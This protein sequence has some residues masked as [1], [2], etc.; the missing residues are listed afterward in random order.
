MSSRYYDPEIGRFTNADKVDLLGANGDLVS[1]NLF[2]YCGNNPV[3]RTDS[4]GEAYHILIGAAVGLVAGLVGQV[5]TDVTTRLLTGEKHIS[6]WQTYVG[7][8]VGGAVGG[9][10]LAATGNV[11]ASNFATGFFTTGTS[12]VL[13]KVF[14]E[15]DRSWGEIALNS[16]RDGAVSLALGAFLPGAKNVTSGRNNMSAVYRAGLTKLRN[17]TAQRMAVKV[18]GK[19]VVSSIVG[20]LYLDGYYGVMQCF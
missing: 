18:M 3:S 12:Q 4:T 1:Y 15:N 16:T 7:A 2:A 9:A 19:G 13:E 20:G 14:N 17:S 5:I 8:A 11:H 6:N 10:V